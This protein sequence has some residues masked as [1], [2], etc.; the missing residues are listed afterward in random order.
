V[1]VENISDS[2]AL[3][4]VQGPRARDVLKACPLFLPAARALDD[5]E[6]YHGFSFTHEESEVIVT[7]TGY[8]G[9]LGYEVF[10]P[11]GLAKIFWEKMSRAGETFGL[12]PIGL[13]ARDTLRFEASYCLYGHEIDEAT[14]PLEAGL[15]WVVKLKK[16]SFR[17]LKALREEKSRGPKRK[18]VGFELEGR[19]IARQGYPALHGGV[20]VG[21]VT[22]G[23]FA[24]TLQKSLCM[25]LIET[26][27]A[28]TPGPF[29]V[30]IR[31]KSVPASPVPLPFYK[32]RV[33]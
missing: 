9:E 29:A 31:G 2:I 5:T 7:R 3:L 11:P 26:S 17:G 15:A 27:S 32:S 21:S 33:K 12:R 23:A 6:Y 28:E 13:G 25:A 16:D 18:L 8:T 14:S 10:V 4:A 24:P 19:A 20:Q 30:E 22:S 1:R